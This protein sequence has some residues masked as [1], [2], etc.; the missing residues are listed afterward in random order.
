MPRYST[1]E[2]CGTKKV[3]YCDKPDLVLRARVEELERENARLKAKSREAYR[4]CWQI[5]MSVAKETRK[6]WVAMVAQN[7]AIAIAHEGE[8]DA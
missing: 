6:V 2:W 5:C 8:K 7:C 4:T 1:C 3:S